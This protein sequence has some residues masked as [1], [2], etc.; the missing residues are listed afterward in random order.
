MIQV[1]QG[2]DIVELSKFK[3]IYQ[4]NRQ[5][6]SDIFTEKERTYCMSMKEPYIHF[7]GR[8]AAK[9]AFLKAIGR[10]ISVPGVDHI[11][12]EIEITRHRSG[13][14]CLS[15]KGWAAKTSRKKRIS[16]FTV[17]ISHSSNYAI[18]SVILLGSTVLKKSCS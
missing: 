2:I 18:A 11:F 7:A 1:H 10:G 6:V 3:K 16:Q 4:K 17:S 9:E 13:R 15:V 8:F 5:F 12:Q 14:P